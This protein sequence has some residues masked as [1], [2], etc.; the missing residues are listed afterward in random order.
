LRHYHGFLYRWMLHQGGF[1]LCQLYAMAS[2]FD[3]LIHSSEELK[4]SI[5]EY[6]SQI[7]CSVESCSCS[8]RGKPCP[9]GLCALRLFC[10]Y[11]HGALRP[12]CPYGHGALRLFCPYGLCALR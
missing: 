4:R 9:Y 10:P 7:S 5:R 6:T 1:N 8:D 12:F 11:G 3:L 2:D